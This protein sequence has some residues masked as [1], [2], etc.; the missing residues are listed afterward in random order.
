MCKDALSKLVARKK[1]EQS[2]PNSSKGVETDN[3]GKYDSNL[4]VSKETKLERTG[5]L[6][7]A[8]HGTENSKIKLLN[9]YEI[10]LKKVNLDF[11]SRICGCANYNI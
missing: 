6:F 4:I 1:V 11:V 8:Q 9:Y 7:A 10:V 2:F 5:Q 3:D